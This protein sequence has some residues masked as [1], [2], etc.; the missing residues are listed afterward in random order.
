M[1][2]K[3]NLLD[4]YE[5]NLN[6]L[7]GA[8]ASYGFLPTLAL[9]IK[10]ED[11]NN[12]TFET[13][14]KK[15]ESDDQ[16]K[17]LLFMHYYNTCIKP[18]LLVQEGCDEEK[19]GVT[20]QYKL[21]M[22]TLI[23]LLNRQKSNSKRANIFTTN[24][25]NCFESASEELLISK[26]ERFYVN[27][28]GSGFQRRIFNI[29]SFNHRIVNRSFSDRYDQYIPQIN[30]LHAHGSINWEKGEAD[31]EIIINYGDCEFYF[32]FSDDE[33]EL[34][35]AFKDIV[36][37]D[38]KIVAAIDSFKR[39][40]DLEVL[41]I[42][43]FWGN[44]NKIP[45]V[46]PTKWKFHETVFEETYYQILRHLSYELERPNSVLITFGFSFADEHILS[47]V[48]RS[49]SNPSLTLYVSCFNQY[50]YKSMQKK[51]EGFSNVQFIYSDEGDMDFARFNSTRFT[52]NQPKEELCES[53]SE[54]PSEADHQII[55]ASSL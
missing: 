52:V 24:Y 18:G 11:G 28:G 7:I 31:G 45:I 34:L 53:K 38:E 14:A 54:T 35:S 16:V 5:Q 47:L 26:E 23:Q 43:S 36:E 39:D 17:T 29:E 27:D 10:D 20:D 46:N 21:F 8:G 15:Y 42:S 48:K 50:E 4:V 40:N 49:L 32:D 44:Y 37:N 30:L 25:D 1:T 12:C 51:F 19:Q 6:F 3:F 22:K 41:D 9:K 2:D 55:Q 33:K 13:L